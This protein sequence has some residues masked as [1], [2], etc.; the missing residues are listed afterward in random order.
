MA[1][2]SAAKVNLSKRFSFRVKRQTELKF[3][4]RRFSFS[5]AQ[6]RHKTRG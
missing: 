3:A 5:G 2:S 6:T 4:E 1:F